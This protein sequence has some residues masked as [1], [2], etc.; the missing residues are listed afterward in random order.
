MNFTISTEALHTEELCGNE[1]AVVPVQGRMDTVIKPLLVQVSVWSRPLGRAEQDLVSGS[2]PLV[3][4]GRV[5]TCDCSLSCH[6]K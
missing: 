4:V 2:H 3:A 5:C 6:R 1:L